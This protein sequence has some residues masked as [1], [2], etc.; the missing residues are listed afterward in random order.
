MHLLAVWLD[1]RDLVAPFFD[2]DD[3]G[4]RGEAALVAF[5]FWGRAGWHM[6]SDLGGHGGFDGRGELSAGVIGH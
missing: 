3:L 5:A 6:R 1:G 4:V 2:L